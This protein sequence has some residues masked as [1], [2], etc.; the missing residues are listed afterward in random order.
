MLA[1]V[2]MLLEIPMF[3][4]VGSITTV[5]VLISKTVVPVLTYLFKK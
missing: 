2:R 5:P 4:I 1:P 3:M